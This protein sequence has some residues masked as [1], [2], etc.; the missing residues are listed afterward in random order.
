M[1]DFDKD[2]ISLNF[3]QN[4]INELKENSDHAQDIMDSFSAN[5]FASKQKILELI[6]RHSRNDQQEIVIFGCWYGSILIPGLFENASKITGIDLDSAV[7][8]I[9]KNRLFKNYNGIDFIQ[10]DVF[11]KDLSR[12]HTCDL[13]VNTSCEHMRPMKEWPFW[14]YVKAG[15]IYAFQS[16]NMYHIDTHVNCV[17]SLQEFKEQMP[18]NLE[19]LCEHELEEDR[20]TRFTL[21]GKI[22][23]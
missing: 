18:E 22:E 12:Y 11:E 9:A 15:S 23:N 8:K 17:S 20:G 1:I 10:G 21:I 6:Q 3:F 19:I 2:I 7:L 13:F 4:V 14:R 16:N 5:Q